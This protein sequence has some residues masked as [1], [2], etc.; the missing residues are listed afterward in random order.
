MSTTMIPPAYF[1]ER[2]KVLENVFTMAL[3]NVV[4]AFPLRSTYTSYD[5]YKIYV[6]LKNQ[7]M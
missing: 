3:N 7:N 5:T 2:S 1:I 4:K 6:Q